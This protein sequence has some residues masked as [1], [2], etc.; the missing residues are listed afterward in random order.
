MNP[1]D[2]PASDSTGNST[3]PFSEEDRVDGVIAEYLRAADAGPAPDRRELLSRHPDLASQLTA[4]FADQDQA[5]SW[6]NAVRPLIPDSL[7]ARRC[8]CPHCHHALELVA[9]VPEDISCPSCGSTFRV[10]PA[11]PLPLAGQQRLGRFELLEAVGVGS[12]GTVYKAR[13][14]E[15]DRIVAVKIPR[16]GHLAGKED[17]DRF[18][19]EGR[20]LAHIHHPGIV[21]VYEVGQADGL[22]YLVTEFVH[23]KTLAELLRTQRFSPAESAGLIAKVADALHYS[24]GCGIVHRDLKP[25]NILLAVESGGWR[26]EGKRHQKGEADGDPELQGTGNLAVEHGPGGGVLPSDEGLSEGG[27]VRHDQSDSAGRGLDSGEH[28]RRPG[29]GAHQGIPP[30]PECREGF[31]HGAGNPPDA[32]SACR[33]ARSSQG[34]SPSDPDRARQPNALRTP[35]G[36]GKAPLT[37]LNAPPSTLHPK[38]TDFGLAKREGFEATMTVEGQVLG[39]PAYMSPEQAG[40]EAHRVDGRSDVYSL[41]VVLYQMLTGELPF[42]GTVRMLLQH[43]LQDDPRSPRSLNDRVPRDLETIC[44][45][46]LRKEPDKRYQTAGALAEDLRCFLAGKPI[47]ARPIHAWERTLKWAQRRPAVA[48]LLALVIFVAAVGFGLV[49][50]QWQRAQAAGQVAANKAQELEIKN[51]Y[52]NLALAERE[53]SVNNVGRAEE[54]LDA[55]PPHLRSWEWHCLKRLRYRNFPALQQYP[56]AVFSAV[57]SP[58]GRYLASGG[59]DGTVKISEVT[60][61]R[62]VL[63][64]KKPGHDIRSV[65]YS[66][67]G[68]R[69]VTAGRDGI[70]IVWSTTTGEA[71]HTLTGHDGPVS[72][73]RFSPDGNRIASSSWDYTV[74]LWDLA[75]RRVIHTFSGY[76]GAPAVLGFLPG[77]QDLVTCSAGGMV[78]VWDTTTFREVSSFGEQMWLASMA[79]SHDGQRLALGGQDGLVTVLDLATGQRTLTLPGHTLRVGGLAFS[80]D[81]RRLVSGGYD[82]T[83]RFWDTT[84]GQETLTLHGH[85]DTITGLS[86]SPDGQQLVSASEDGT[87]KLWDATPL[88]EEKRDQQVL[89]LRGHGQRVLCVAFSPDSRCLASAS[90]DGTVK[91]WDVLAGQEALTFRG[92]SAYVWGVAFSPDGRQLASTGWDFHVRVW[93]AAGGREIHALRGLGGYK[94]SLTFHPDGRQLAAGTSL[95]KVKVWN[96]TSGQEI[97]TLSAH[98]I[99]FIYS[100]AFSPDGLRFASADWDGIVKV[101]DATTWNPNP[102]RILRGHKG[103]VRCVAFSPDS[104]RLASASENGTVKVF[105]VEKGEEVLNLQHTDRVYSVAFSP[106]GRHLASGGWDQMVRIWDAASGQPLH[107]LSGHAGYVWSVAFSPDGKRLASASGYEGRGE[108]KIWNTSLWEK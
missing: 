81:D 61:G 65:A 8:H 48:A 40:G 97:R 107:T 29:P 87:V 6:T 22:P 72:R 85:A 36:P 42:R 10:E 52:Q 12:F 50:W 60:T 83:L 94:F 53:L 49:T 27:T 26:V 2:K 104:K 44:L 25:S 19:R 51:Y 106:D 43:V 57:F 98:D 31:T 13:D 102:L 56:V 84:T 99:A 63:T 5:Q 108:I 28:C 20:S 4:F 33:V 35:Q 68:Q 95:G 79:L 74:K 16:A 86:F 77:G 15:L 18:L 34:G 73:A 3:V 37:T 105:D 82:K 100:V 93:D 9:V 103:T 78:K 88:P 45:K 39:T 54:I 92:H 32:E 62:E 17:L 58:D 23:G 1:L 7:L 80:D 69:L 96:P 11:Q 59:R 55:C 101:W 75:T 66:A 30:S 76:R 47:Q 71:L 64:F 38:I 90:W 91:I 14:P 89:T 70:I 46:C 21:P 41:G 67:D 24:H